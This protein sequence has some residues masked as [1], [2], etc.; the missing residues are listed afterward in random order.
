LNT[1]QQARDIPRQITQALPAPEPVIPAPVEAEITPAPTM[2]PYVSPMAEE[3]EQGALARFKSWTA[4]KLKKVTEPISRNVQDIQQ[5]AEGY[6][7]RLLQPD[8]AENAFSEKAL[9]FRNPALADYFGTEL[10]PANKL[11]NPE[12]PVLKVK[13]KRIKARQPAEEPAPE[14]PALGAQGRDIGFPMRQE[15]MARQQQTIIPVEQDPEAQ[16]Q[17]LQQSTESHTCGISIFTCLF[18]GF[19][20]NIHIDFAD[21]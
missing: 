11:L 14:Q 1:S 10:T 19:G 17:L 7:P 21:V 4:T 15:L 8:E 18:S 2:T 20:I 6:R 13:G 9:T 5:T 12:R 16:R 3:A